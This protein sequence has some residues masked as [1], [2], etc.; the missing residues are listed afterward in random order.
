MA[1]PSE[2]DELKVEVKNFA[3]HLKTE[4]YELQQLDDN[5]ITNIFSLEPYKMIQTCNSSNEQFDAQTLARP[6]HCTELLKTRREVSPE[7]ALIDALA[8]KYRDFGSPK[9]R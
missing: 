1:R 7:E 6:K 5:G 8:R 3:T 4:S 2:F 9:L